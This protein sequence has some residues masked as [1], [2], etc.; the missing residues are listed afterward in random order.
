LFL[1]LRRWMAFLE[2]AGNTAI[3]IFGVRGNERSWNAVSTFFQSN[4]Q[5][6][7]APHVLCFT[8]NRD[9]FGIGENDLDGQLRELVREI[10]ESFISPGFDIGDKLVHSVGRY[11]VHRLFAFLSK[12]IGGGLDI[13]LVRE[14]YGEWDSM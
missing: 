8:G 9:N 14:G 6:V 2:T 10:A 13:C 4:Y 11:R 5:I 1:E 7:F 12:F 3:Q